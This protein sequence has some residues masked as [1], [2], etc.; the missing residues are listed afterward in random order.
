L[1]S[2]YRVELA[3]RARRDLRRLDRQVRER[4]LDALQGLTADPAVGDVRP[5][6]G[7]AGEQRLRVGDWRVIFVLDHD[8][9][10]LTVV[11][12][13]HRSSAYRA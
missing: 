13:A 10:V 4:I 12:V 7:R 2:G 11:R 3:P 6:T 1:T 9:R 5:L 8:N